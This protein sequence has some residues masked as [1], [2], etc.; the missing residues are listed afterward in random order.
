MSA[1]YR[2]EWES[3]EGGANGEISSTAIEEEGAWPAMVEV[4]LYGPACEFGFTMT[5]E[6]AQDLAAKIDSAARRA[7]HQNVLKRIEIRH[8]A[9]PPQ[10]EKGGER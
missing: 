6:D 9:P 4:Q 7:N 5:V 10:S 1:T 3:C 2:A 8:A